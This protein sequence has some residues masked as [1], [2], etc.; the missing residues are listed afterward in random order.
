[1]RPGPR[2]RGAQETGG[3]R[4]TAGAH[5]VARGSS[6]NQGHMNVTLISIFL[7]SKGRFIQCLKKN[8][9]WPGGPVSAEGRAMTPVPP[10]GYVFAILTDIHIPLPEACDT[11]HRPIIQREFA[12]GGSRNSPVC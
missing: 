3:P 8:I 12:L 1:M 5:W 2:L 4:M 11:R 6:G 9:P 7:S 10:L